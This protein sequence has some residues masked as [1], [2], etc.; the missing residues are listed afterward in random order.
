MHA[1]RT[2]RTALIIVA[3]IAATAGL[4]GVLVGYG[5]LGD[6]PQHRSLLHNPVSRFFGREH[7]WLWPVLAVAGAILTLACLYWLYVLLFSTDR[8]HAIRLTGQ[9]DEGGRT[10]LNPA[11]LTQAVAGEIAGYPGVSAARA[12]LL[13]DMWKP[14]LVVTA[15]LEDSADL[16]SLRRRI[17]HEAIAHARTAVDDPTLPVQLDLTVTTKRA[18]RAA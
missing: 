17:E 16:A 9:H 1:D 13:G 4:F 8:A 11:A 7:T 14:T 12:R 6:G 3:L 10:T 18:G 15:V 5:V 2:N